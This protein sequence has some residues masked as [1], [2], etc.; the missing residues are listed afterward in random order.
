MQ[1]TITLTGHSSYSQIS[2]GIQMF[3]NFRKAIQCIYSTS[4]TLPKGPGTAISNQAYSLF[5][6][7]IY[8]YPL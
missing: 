6:S 1:V 7:K 3:P 2:L 8:E 5:Y 4:I